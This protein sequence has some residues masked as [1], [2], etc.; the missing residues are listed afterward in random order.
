M[1]RTSS[2]KGHNPSH[3]TCVNLQRKGHRVS[4]TCFARGSSFVTRSSALAPLTATFFDDANKLL[5]LILLLQNELLS[6]TCARRCGAESSLTILR[7]MGGVLA[8]CFPPAALNLHEEPW[9]SWE[10]HPQ[11][12]LYVRDSSLGLVIPIVLRTV[13]CQAHACT[14]ISTGCRPGNISDGLVQLFRLLAG[15]LDLVRSARCAGSRLA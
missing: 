2:C 11:A 8:T 12:R 15:S 4:A 5:R 7:K 3:S 10:G 1:R 13:P 6:R 9:M 14:G